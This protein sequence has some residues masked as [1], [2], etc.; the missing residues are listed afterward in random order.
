MFADMP[1]YDDRGINPPG[2]EWPRLRCFCFFKDDEDPT[3]PDLIRVLGWSLPGLRVEYYHLDKEYSRTV[4]QQAIPQL[5]NEINVLRDPEQAPLRFRSV[6]SKPEVY[7]PALSRAMAD[8]DVP[9]KRYLEWATGMIRPR[10]AYTGPT[11]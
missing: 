8:D 5:L 10:G 7:L 1:D 9:F 4:S 3:K 2:L 6:A 11:R